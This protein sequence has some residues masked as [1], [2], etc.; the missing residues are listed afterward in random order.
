V[1]RRELIAVLGGAGIVW[2]V[3]A[4]AQPSVPVIG[5]LGSASPDAFALQ[6][7]A[8]RQGLKEAGYVEN[9]TVAI[10]YRWALGQYDRLAAMASE[11]VGRPVAVIVA[12]GID[13]AIAA[14]KATATIPIVMIGVGDP[15][16]TGLVA[17]LAHPGANVTG[18][19]VLG[20]ELGSKRLE[21]LRQALPKLSRVAL[22]WNPSNSA[23]ERVFRDVQ[24]GAEAKGVTLQSVELA[25]PDQF[26]SV[27]DAMLVQHPDGLMVTGDPMLQGLVGGIVEFC[28]RK[29]LPTMFQLREPVAA[30]GFMSYGASLPD[31]FRR[32]ALYVGKILKGAKPGDLPVEQPAKF[33]LVI[34]LKTATA[35]GLTVPPTLLAG[36][37]E[38]IE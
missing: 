22:L 16:R 20:S 17:S 31:L 28:T 15:L 1:R 5:F 38:V 32:G 8:F 13:P 11:L 36:A 23:N 30:G 34:N 37:D 26:Q 4:P 10:E 35:L 33:D 7:V 27:L 12:T 29:R 14:N 25:N 6:L 3:A 2:P 19:T 24:A 9:E 18:N 21:L